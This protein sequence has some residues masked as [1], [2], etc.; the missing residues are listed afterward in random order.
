MK[1]PFKKINDAR[2]IWKALGYWDDIYKEMQVK[3]LKELLLSKRVWV[4][5]V[6]ILASVSHILPPEKAVVLI[7]VGG[8]ITKVIDIGLFSE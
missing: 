2:H 6:G 3:K 8:A 4:G 1:N 5:I 7:G